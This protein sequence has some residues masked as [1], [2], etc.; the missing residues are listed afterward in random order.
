M[1]LCIQTICEI[2]INNDFEQKIRGGDV[3]DESNLNNAV[4]KTNSSNKNNAID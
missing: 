2:S 1:Q 3:I 4:D